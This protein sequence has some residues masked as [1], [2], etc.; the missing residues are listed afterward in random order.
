M[1]VLT[2]TQVIELKG[3]VSVRVYTLP[4]HRCVERIESKDFII[5][6]WDF[7]LKFY[8]KIQY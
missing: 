5:I 4:G 6:F 2:L 7:L 3:G 8:K 1:V